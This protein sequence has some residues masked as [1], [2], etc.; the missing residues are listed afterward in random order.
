M[1]SVGMEYFELLMLVR[2][3]YQLVGNY[4]LSI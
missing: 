2:G 3:N 4:H 1:Q